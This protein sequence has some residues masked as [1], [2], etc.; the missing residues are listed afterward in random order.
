MSMSRTLQV[1]AYSIQEMAEQ[2]D[3]TVKFTEARE[4]GLPRCAKPSGQASLFWQQ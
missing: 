4:A 3:D 1:S 2:G